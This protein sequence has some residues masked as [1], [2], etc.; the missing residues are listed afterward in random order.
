MAK[1]PISKQERKIYLFGFFYMFLVLIPVIVPFFQSFGLSM[2]EIFKLQAIFGIGVVIFEVPTGYVADIFGRKVS[3]V[4]GAILASIGFFGFIIGKSFWEFAMVEFVL[5]LG[6]SFISGSDDALLYDSLPKNDRK[7]TSHAFA[8]Y[9]LSEQCGESV[10]SLLGGFLATISLAYVIWGQ[11]FA[12]LIAILVALTIKESKREVSRK[13]KEN[14]KKVLREIFVGDPILRLTFINS[15]LWGLS[16]FIAVWTYQKHWQEVGIPL[17]FFG[18]LW[19]GYNISTGIVGK[20]VH[21]WEHKYGARKVLLAMALLPSLGY[22]GLGLIPGMFSVVFGILHYVSR[23][24]NG[25]IMSDAMNWRLSSDF[26]ATAGSIK[27][28]AFR[29]GFALVGPAV[30]YSIDQYSLRTTY[31][32]LGSVFL[33]LI[34]LVLMPLIRR[35]EAMGKLEIPHS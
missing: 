19:A 34:P 12:S 29:L 22:F 23:G 25:V 24:I 17:A 35:I 1:D 11:F 6:T 8:N 7:R 13:H 18:V 5:S 14:F 15:I 20:G 10:A 30:G 28:F 2:A 33:L 31:L 4:L 27:S 3:L 32:I 21:S 26:R 9:Q 16:T